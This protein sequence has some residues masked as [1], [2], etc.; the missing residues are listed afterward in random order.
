MPAHD[1]RRLLVVTPSFYPETFRI[2]E[3]VEQ[4]ATRNIAVTVLTGLPNYP[5]GR[6]YEGYKDA[7]RRS[8][9][10]C[11]AEIIRVPHLPRGG[12]GVLQRVMCLASFLISGRIN[13]AAK[14]RDRVFD[15]VFCYGLSPIYAA[16]LA[17]ALGRK[18]KAPT[19]LWLQDLWPG[20][21]AAAGFRPIQ[22]ATRVLEAWAAR[23]YRRSDLVLCSSQGFLPEVERVAGRSTSCTYHPNPAEMSVF[24]APIFSLGSEERFEVVF[25]GN[26]GRAI[27]AQTILHAAERLAGERDIHFRLVGDG[28]MAA[29]LRAEI[30]CRNLK[31]I[32]LENRVSAEQ[33]PQIYNRASALLLTLADDATM[34][35][36]LPS[37]LST[38]LASGRPVIAAA[39]GETARIVEE[40]GGGICVPAGDAASLAR[41]VVRLRDMPQLERQRM[42]LAGRFFAQTHFDPELLA[43]SLI[44]R[45]GMMIAQRGRMAAR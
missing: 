30:A 5:E 22:V 18:H 7:W 45:L 26:I 43:K 41:E 9:T 4:L 15:A 39:N 13:G 44:E 12:G 36:S 40:S 17:L 35:K 8:E 2:N 14:L 1:L 38:Y 21:L 32:T 11:G 19:A 23:I 3:V 16:E 37:K 10:A 33:M 34:D 6:I 27:S 31:N 42:A 29:W 24:N 28:S 25:A 20:S